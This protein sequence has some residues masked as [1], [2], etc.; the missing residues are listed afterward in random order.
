MSNCFDILGQ[1][2]HMIYKFFE[3]GETP[4]PILLGAFQL[5]GY[6]LHQVDQFTQ[7]LYPPANRPQCRQ[8]SSRQKLVRLISEE[9]LSIRA[10]Y[11]SLYIL[12]CIWGP[13]AHFQVCAFFFSVVSAF[14]RSFCFWAILLISLYSSD[15]RQGEPQRNLTPL[16]LPLRTVYTPDFS[17]KFRPTLRR[18]PSH[19]YL[20]SKVQRLK[21]GCWKVKDSLSMC[22]T[23]GRFCRIDKDALQVK[24]AINIRHSNDTCEPF[25]L[26]GNPSPYC[27][28]FR[29]A[30][31]G[32][33]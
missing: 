6:I 25:L 5:C 20:Y 9:S 4:R 31:S 26:F 13:A 14:F 11:F 3:G 21:S 30:S 22:R 27:F 24:G 15:L 1:T 16:S 8:F 33:Y 7:A 29:A 12:V 32:K 19:C 18:P 10:L 28:L 2:H 23:V 17:G